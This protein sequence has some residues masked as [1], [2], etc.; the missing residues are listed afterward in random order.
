MMPIRHGK[1]RVFPLDFSARE[2]PACRCILLVFHPQ[3]RSIVIKPFKRQNSIDKFP[4]RHTTV[5]NDVITR[6][7]RKRFACFACF[8][9]FAFGMT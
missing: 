2:R 9:C 6:T 7:R 4:L 5:S 1:M 8:A 3:A